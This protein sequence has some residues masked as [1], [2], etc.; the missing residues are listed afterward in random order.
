[1]KG[2]SFGKVVTTAPGLLP[3]PELVLSSLGK[4]NLKNTI[5][6]KSGCLIVVSILGWQDVSVNIL[7][8]KYYKTDLP[9]ADNIS[10]NV[11]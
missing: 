8:F 1:M 11:I 6:I 9:S 7:Y 4:K 2:L 10:I 3:G 5:R